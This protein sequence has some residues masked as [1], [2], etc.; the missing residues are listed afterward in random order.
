VRD[1][2]S[3]TK[4]ILLIYRGVYNVEANAG[5]NLASKSLTTCLLCLQILPLSHVRSCR[6]VQ[7]V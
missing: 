7:S 3:H 2:V 4:N 5:G 6:G 1:K